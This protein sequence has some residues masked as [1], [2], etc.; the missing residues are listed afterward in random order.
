MVFSYGVLLLSALAGAL[1][2]MFGGI[3]NALIPLFAIGA[4]SAFTMS[5]FG[6]VFHWRKSSEPRAKRSMVMNA[7]GATTTFVTLCVVLVAKF[8]EGA[9]ITLPLVAGIVLLLRGI[10]RHYDEIY[11]CTKTDLSLD[12]GPV[13]APLVVVPLRRWD[14]K[15]LKALRLSLALSQ[16]VTVVQVLT[17]DRTLEDLTG[18]WRELAEG[19]AIAL[20]LSPPRLVVLQSEYRELFGPLLRFVH[21]LTV[22]NPNREIAVMIPELVEVRWYHYLLHN[23]TS[24]I[25]K[26]LLLHRGGPQIVIVNVPWHLDAVNPERQMLH[27]RIRAWWSRA[28]QPRA[29]GGT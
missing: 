24:A 29:G 20:G 4:L 27:R 15:S 25:M 8:K 28:W 16:D 3:T 2:V 10:R 13:N 26:T 5:Q 14:A 7:V 18:R 9:W 23:Q 6:M 19:P 11:E 1:L 12:V 17:K 21:R 22:E